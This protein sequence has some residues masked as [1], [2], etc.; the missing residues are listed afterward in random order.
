MLQLLFL[1]ASAPVVLVRERA[2]WISGLTVANLLAWV[3]WDV[4]RGGAWVSGVP[5][6]ETAGM[7]L[8]VLGSIVLA[9][10]RGHAETKALEESVQLRQM[11]VRSLDDLLLV[12]DSHT[13]TV[14]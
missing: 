3:A 10:V 9:A 5:L 1:A 14:E 12:V 11:L 2:L 6:F 13:F 4:F 7:A 8:G